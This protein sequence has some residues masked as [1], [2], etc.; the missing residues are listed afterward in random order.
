MGEGP[1]FSADFSYQYTTPNTCLIWASETQ[2]VIVLAPSESLTKPLFFQI[3]KLL[4]PREYRE[5]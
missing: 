5:K 4:E 1:Y 2:I 3:L